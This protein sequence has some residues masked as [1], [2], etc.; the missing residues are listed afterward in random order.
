ML[1]AFS[2]LLK[3]DHFSLL[4]SHSKRSP[5]TM[6]RKNNTKE[7]ILVLEKELRISGR[8]GNRMVSS[9]SKIKKIKETKKNCKENDCRLFSHGEN[10][11]SKGL[12]FSS[13]LADFIEM[14]Q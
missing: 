1:T 10:P 13:S 7:I 3:K 12:S 14:D 9:T 5:K 8:D 11:H 2:C 6:N 4:L